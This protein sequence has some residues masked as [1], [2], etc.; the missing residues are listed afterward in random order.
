LT[1][2]TYDDVF[3]G[4][5]DSPHTDF[6]ER[7]RGESRAPDQPAETSVGSGDYKAFGF[8]PT[9]AIGETC[10]LRWWID[11]TDQ[12]EGLEFAYRFMLK[13]GYIGEREIRIYLPDTIVVI[14][15]QNLF[16]LRKKLARRQ[17][18][19]VQQWSP[20]VWKPALRDE[21]SVDRI[22]VLRTP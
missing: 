3:G 11:G 17:C 10:D 19:F 2:D 5:R 8:M 16:D 18:T 1:D 7:L 4:R 14:A 20:R 21:A 12:A 9:S 22:D 15:G 6:R 13:I